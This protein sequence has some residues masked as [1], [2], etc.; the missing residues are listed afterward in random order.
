MTYQDLS[1]RTRKKTTTRSLNDIFLC[2]V[3][4]VL[5]GTVLG[6]VT[7]KAELTTINT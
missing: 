2:L 6:P 5:Q 1:H 4:G 7:F 3:D